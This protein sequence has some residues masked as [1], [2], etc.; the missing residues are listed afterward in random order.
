MREKSIHW[1]I[2]HE[3]PGIL[4]GR[5]SNRSGKLQTFRTI[6]IKGDRLFT[7]VQSFPVEAE[8]GSRTRPTI[9][10]RPASYLVE[11]ND[12]C[13]H[14]KQM[15][16][17]GRSRD[18]RSAFD[19]A[20]SLENA[21]QALLRPDTPPSQCRNSKDALRDMKQTDSNIRK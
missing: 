10:V 7:L 1:V 18:K 20:E 13:P 5:G 11:A 16:S 17:T 14:L 3:Q 4:A 12:F 21:I 9:K 6:E 2:G 8:S 15:Q 19:D